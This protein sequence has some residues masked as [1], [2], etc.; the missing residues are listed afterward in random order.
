MTS[1]CGRGGSQP[2]RAPL[3]AQRWAPSSRRCPAQLGLWVAQTAPAHLPALP[4]TQLPVADGAGPAGL[5]LP[6]RACA[7]GGTWEQRD[8]KG[9]RDGSLPISATG[10]VLPRPPA[11]RWCSHRTAFNHG[12]QWRFLFR[13]RAGVLTRRMPSSEP[14]RLHGSSASPGRA[15]AGAAAVTDAALQTAGPGLGRTLAPAVQTRARVRSG[16]GGQ[17]TTE[18]FLLRV[19]LPVLVSSPRLAKAVWKP[20]RPAAVLGV[21]CSILMIPLPRQHQIS[22][23]LSQIGI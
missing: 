20:A 9:P 4:S 14:R 13:A 17:T 16:P 21:Q 5:L 19:T 10:K 22:Q 23:K 18:E 7:L 3:R 1:R 11:A 12:T 2:I 8:G 6:L 15:Q